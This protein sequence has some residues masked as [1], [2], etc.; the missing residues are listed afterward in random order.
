MQ[1]GRE[2]KSFNLTGSV[3][4][5]DTHAKIIN[6]TKPS[7]KTK[8]PKRLSHAVTG[9]ATD[10]LNT[11][12]IASTLEGSLYVSAPRTSTDSSSSTS[13]Q[14]RYCTLRH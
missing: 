10:A 12:L 6:K 1:S 8:A 4:G 5:G 9:L 11:L 13:T 7:T 3:A 2:R 14:Q